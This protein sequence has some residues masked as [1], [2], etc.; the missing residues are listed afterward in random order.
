MQV[1]KTFFKLIYSYRKI[2]LIYFLV[3]LGMVTI[4][5]KLQYSK[6]EAGFN[7][8]RLRVG[9]IDNDKSEYTKGMMEYFK[10]NH[11]MKYIEYDKEAILDELY[12]KSLDYVLVIPEGFTQTL[13]NKTDDIELSN[14]KVPGYFDSKNSASKYPG[15]FI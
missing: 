4:L 14:M 10:A 1:F 11:D 9:V 12:W 13:E 5:T 8:E 3:F 7:Q 2:I 6:K 15:T